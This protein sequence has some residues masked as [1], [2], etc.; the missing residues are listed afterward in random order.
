M[1][2]PEAELRPRKPTIDEVACSP[3]TGKPLARLTMVKVERPEIRY[4]PIP[5]PEMTEAQR[6]EYEISRVAPTREVVEKIVEVAEVPPGM[7]FFYEDDRFY[8]VTDYR[9]VPIAYDSILN[10]VRRAMRPLVPRVSAIERRLA[11]YEADIRAV[12][13]D[14]EFKKYLEEEVGLAWEAYLRQTPLDKDAIRREFA[15][16]FIKPP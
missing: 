10:R 11:R 9:L 4:E 15:K 12:E 1:W 6:R 7:F 8:E 5:W 16:R 13:H 2:V 3:I 14:P